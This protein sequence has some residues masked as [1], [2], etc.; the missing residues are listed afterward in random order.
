[1]R[2]RKGQDHAVPEGVSLLPVQDRNG[3]DGPTVDQLLRSEPAKSGYLLKR[4][5]P[6]LG[7]CPLCCRGNSLAL[8]LTIDHGSAVR[9]K[10]RYFVL[11]GSYLFRFES[12]HSITPKG[13][14]LPVDVCDVSMDVV[15]EKP[16]VVVRTLR[17]DSVL[18]SDSPG[19]CK[20]W[21][22]AIN[23]AKQRTIK[24]RLGHSTTNVKFPRFYLLS[25]ELICD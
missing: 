17:G 15:D 20:E 3:E 10:E 21:I 13:T 6:F 12:Q 5:V 7:V 1:M 2:R 22:D 11:I 8:L 24:E 9:W 19:E 4:D 25:S 14:P 18:A 23:R 16:C